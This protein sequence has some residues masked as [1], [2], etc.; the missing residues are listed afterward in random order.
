MKTAMEC[1]MVFSISRDEVHYKSWC[2]LN[3]LEFDLQFF[4]AK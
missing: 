2:K 4:K 1:Y 3:H